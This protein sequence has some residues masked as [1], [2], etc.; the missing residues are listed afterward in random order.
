M[1]GWEM[2]KLGLHAHRGCGFAAMPAMPCQ[3]AAGRQAKQGPAALMLQAAHLKVEGL[4]AI[5]SH[6]AK[7]LQCNLLDEALVRQQQQVLVVCEL[8]DGQ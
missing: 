3:G 5:G 7:L 1:G 6:T 4:H 8:T 2:I